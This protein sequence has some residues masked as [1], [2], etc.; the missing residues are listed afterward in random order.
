MKNLYYKI[1]VDAIV[2]E[3]TKHGH[4]RNWKP[5]TLIPISV[6]QGVNLLTVFFWLSTINVKIDIFVD[7][8]IFPGKMIDVF[9][10]GFLTLFLPFILLNYALIFRGKKYDTLIEK[11]GYRNGKLYL[12]YFLTTVGVFILPIIF[13]K[14]I[15]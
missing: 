13:M 4:L 14:W 8:N 10:S 9:L 12:L 3:R 2:Y 11:Y 5:Y 15:I 7:L 6:L 1:W